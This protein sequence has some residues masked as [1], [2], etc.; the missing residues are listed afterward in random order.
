MESFDLVQNFYKQKKQKRYPSP[1]ISAP[2]EA[3]GG[4]W[5]I[6]NAVSAPKRQFKLANAFTGFAIFSQQGDELGEGIDSAKSADASKEGCS[7]TTHRRNF[8]ENLWIFWENLKIL[9]IF[10][11]IHGNLSKN[12]RFFK[13]GVADTARFGDITKGSKSPLNLVKNF[14]AQKQ[15]T[16]DTAHFG[17]ITGDRLSSPNL[18]VKAQGNRQVYP[19]AILQ[20]KC[21]FFK[22]LP[23]CPIIARLALSTKALNGAAGQQKRKRQESPKSTRRGFYRCAISQRTWCR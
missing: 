6:I 14:G 11:E 8:S 3:C 20:E 13:K 7:F 21:L 22:T 1:S 19:L 4:F 16:T 2:D 18:A 23:E 9:W 15:G 12:L 10:V 5:H 17:S